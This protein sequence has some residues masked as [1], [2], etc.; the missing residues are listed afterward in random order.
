M[1][2]AVLVVSGI[3]IETL[4]IKHRVNGAALGDIYIA[5]HP[6]YDLLGRTD[7]YGKIV[8]MLMYSTILIYRP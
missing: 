8:V 2:F 7:I 5:W 3:Q 4:K 6:G 1:I